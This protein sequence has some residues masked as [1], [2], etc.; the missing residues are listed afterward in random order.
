MS[1]TE[2]YGEQPGEDHGGYLARPR[3][4]RRIRRR[5]QITVAAAAVALIAAAVPAIAAAT[6]PAITYFAC[7]TKSTGAIRIVGKAASCGTGKH[8]ISWNN[9]GPQGRR[10]KRGPTGA[11][12]GFIDVSEAT[13]QLGGILGTVATLP[14]PAGRYLITAKADASIG[15]TDSSGD[16]VICNLTDSDGHFLD[17]TSAS[18]NPG[19]NFTATESL[20][21]LGA[22]SLPAKGNVQLR[23]EDDTGNAGSVDGVVITAV[24]VTTITQSSG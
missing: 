17:S 22:T 11:V 7:V 12:A 14:L 13:Q 5:G 20:T 8:K 24:P 10:G 15:T 1:P 9:A 4:R 16:A 2:G 23:C 21:L 3:G 19:Q 18:L 6:T